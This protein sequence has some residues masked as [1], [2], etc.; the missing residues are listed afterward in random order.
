MPHTPQTAVTRLLQSVTDSRNIVPG[1]RI[2]VRPQLIVLGP[3]DG[4]AALKAFR[5]AGG[6]K[7]A[8]ASRV[9][10][11]SDDNLPAADA[12][13]ASRRK[14]LLE[15]AAQAGVTNIIPA[16]GCEVAHLIDNALVVPGE[17]AVSNLVE[18]HRLGGIGAL[19]LRV[20]IRDLAQLL[21]GKALPL[22]VPEPVRVDLTGQRQASVA[23][24]DVFFTL[25]REISRNRLVGKALEI[26][27]EG[28]AGFSLHERNQ[29]CAQA[30][31]AGLGSVICLP[32]RSG[33]AE[34][35]QR[36]VRPY[37][38][39][40][41][42]KEATYAHRAALDLA[43]TQLS[44]VPPGNVDGWQTVGEVSGEPVLHVIIG[45][46]GSCGLEDMRLACEII[47]LR[48]LNPRVRC[49]VIP[50]SREVYAQALKADL[51]SQLID[52]GAE[53]HPPGT[54]VAGLLAQQ[55][56]LVT[57]ITASEGCWRAGITVTATAACA[58]AIVH[59]E[60][61]DAQPQRDSKLSGR[62]AKPSS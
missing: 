36:I 39:V 57:G 35:N 25:R 41:P 45:G 16:A 21:A 4:L 7:L 53:V 2:E 51:V 58:G 32:D 37:T 56:A 40:E 52:A 13:A 8:N 9:V 29:L 15:A 27:G 14:Q 60:R 12:A 59:P 26:G 23:G 19:G 55:P 61:L 18:I 33:V 30:A 62:R 44:V 24:R 47:K 22:T 3:R 28:L 11:F 43:H 17:L 6:E 38:T 34:L 10:L 1:D 5:L 50:N 31:H 42:E 20:T 49:D 54:D 48:R 46:E